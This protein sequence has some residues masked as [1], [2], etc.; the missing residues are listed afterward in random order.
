M[1]NT[2]AERPSLSLSVFLSGHHCFPLLAS[3]VY[4][5]LRQRSGSSLSGWEAR[6]ETLLCLAEHAFRGPHRCTAAQACAH[7]DVNVR[8]QAGSDLVSPR[9][10]VC[11]CACARLV[12][13]CLRT[14]LGFR[15][16]LCV[17]FVG[18]SVFSV[19]P[20]SAEGFSSCPSTGSRNEEKDWENDSTT[21]STPSNAEYTGI[22]Q[23][24]SVYRV[25]RPRRQHQIRAHVCVF[26]LQGPKLYKE[27]SAKS[28]K[29]IIQNALAHCCLAGRVNEGQ[30]NKILD[31][32]SAFSLLP[33]SLH[34]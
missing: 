29:H 30:K 11:V 7:C 27:P 28:N 5:S 10:C 25:W 16:G 6:A 3:S 17:S 33:R 13:A 34:F 9:V 20:D 23:T 31:V 12:C 26:L 19:R 32:C 8:Q 4:C 24:W 2:G 15:V 1:T 18:L 21:S 14:S 22:R